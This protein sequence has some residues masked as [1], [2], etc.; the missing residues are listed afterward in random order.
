MPKHTVALA[1]D[2]RALAVASDGRVLSVRPSVV[3]RLGEQRGLSALDIARRRPVD[4]SARHW[5]DLAG[6]DDAAAMASAELERRLSADV[7][8]GAETIWLAVGAAYS[9]SALGRVLGVTRALN[10]PVA[11]FV[12]AAVATVAA[13]A[14]ERHAIVVEMGLSSVGATLVDSGAVVRRRR[15]VSS[16]RGGFADLQ[17]SWLDLISVA[18]VKSTRFDPLHEAVSEQA[19]FDALPDLTNR[20]TAEGQVDVTLTGPQGEPYTVRLARDQFAAAGAAIYGVLERQIHD[21][22]S[23][24]T[25]LTLVVPDA[26]L[27]LPGLLQRLETF[28]GCDLLVVPEGFAAA[29]TSCLPSASR[30]ADAPVRLLRRLPRIDASQLEPVEPPRPL[31]SPAVVE[32]TFSHV[33][34]DG[35]ALPLGQRGIAVGRSGNAVD[36]ALPEGLAGVSRRHCTFVQEATGVTLVDHSRHGTFVNDE[37]VAGRMRV[38]AG[39]RVRIGEPGVELTL[40]SVGVTDGAPPTN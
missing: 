6:D 21:L 38:R 13:L 25:P 29:A 1:L 33:L 18:M 16:T 39:D 12:D 31:G 14:L 37:R 4:V 20:V 24:G 3:H 35:R 17:Q 36:I 27:R 40:I 23:G 15:G 9:P 7:A 30:D 10:W 11:G 26:L 28:V 8:Q 5:R 34:F 19:L 2:D 22:R 32:H